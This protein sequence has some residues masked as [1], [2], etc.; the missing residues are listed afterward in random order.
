[1]ET[2]LQEINGWICAMKYQCPLTFQDVLYKGF[3]CIPSI[4]FRYLIYP[5]YHCRKNREIEE[6]EVIYEA[7]DEDSDGEPM[8]PLHLLATGVSDSER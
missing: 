7:S 1:M 5:C 2:I 3:H 4:I 6:P 8:P